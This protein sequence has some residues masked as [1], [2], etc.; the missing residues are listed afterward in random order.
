MGSHRKQDF[1]DVLVTCGLSKDAANALYLYFVYDRGREPGEDYAKK[2]IEEIL[3]FEFDEYR[4]DD[5][6][7]EGIF[8]TFLRPGKLRGLTALAKDTE[9]ST[10]HFM[11]FR[12]RKERE[13]SGDGNARLEAQRAASA[14]DMFPAW[15]L[16]LDQRDVKNALTGPDL[17]AMQALHAAARARLKAAVDAFRRHLVRIR[18]HAEGLERRAREARDLADEF[19]GQ[20]F[21]A[22][23]TNTMSSRRGGVW[24][25]PARRR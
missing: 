25:A 20:S 21:S 12:Q 14:G 3:R 4:N 11:A 15:L 5:G 24:H 19:E 22:S 17:D 16:D 6:T 8:E 9:E 23:P 10:V 1:T 7:G 13:L 18:K 2:R